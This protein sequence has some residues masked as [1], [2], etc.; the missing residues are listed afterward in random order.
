MR[1][2]MELI[3][4]QF[5]RGRADKKA[6][7]K[8]RKDD[9]SREHLSLPRF[10]HANT[11]EHGGGAVNPARQDRDDEGSAIL[12][13]GSWSRGVKLLPLRTIVRG[14]RSFDLCPIDIVG[15]PA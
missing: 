13:F 12:A 9:A 14:R 7:N 1:Y 8:H 3:G 11:S 15:G 10:F 4:G 5:I 6:S 2:S